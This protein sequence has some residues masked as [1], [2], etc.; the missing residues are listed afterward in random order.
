L[1]EVRIVNLHELLCKYLSQGFTLDTLSKITGFSED[2]LI[3][4]VNAPAFIPQEK[5]EIRM[6]KYLHVFLTRMYDVS[7]MEQTFFRD[8]VSSLVNYFGISYDAIASYLD[9]SVPELLSIINSKD[10]CPSKRQYE[11]GILYLFSTL[12]HDMRFTVGEV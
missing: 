7:P 4:I 12:T 6:F 3:K 11:L 10:C 2:A 5:S 8:L 9:I 1:G